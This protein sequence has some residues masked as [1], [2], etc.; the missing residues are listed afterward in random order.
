MSKLGM[1]APENATGRA[2]TLLDSVK[3]KLGMTPNM[4]RTMAM[5]PS[6]L[7]GYLNFAGALASGALDVKVRER[8]ALAVAEA[9]GC[10][11]CLAAHSLLGKSVGLSIAEIT[12]ARKG[13]SSDPRVA[14]AVGFAVELVRS[15]GAVDGAGLARLKSVGYTDGEIAEIVANVAINLF[16]NY[17][18][19]VADTAIDFPPAAPLASAA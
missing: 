17:F 7:E 11:Y 5:S 13:G 6:V 15:R 1:I 12:A 16:T 14:E 9:N 8:I 3:A 2:K 4:M 10:N 18:N 19:L